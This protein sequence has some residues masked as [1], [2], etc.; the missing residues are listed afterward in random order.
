MNETGESASYH[1][2]DYG[3]GRKNVFTYLGKRYAYFAGNIT[4]RKDLGGG[5]GGHRGKAQGEEEIGFHFGLSSNVS[6]AIQ[7]ERFGKKLFVMEIQALTEVAGWFV[8]LTAV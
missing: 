2:S 4:W 1:S 7:S 5:A 3:G 8:P 6:L